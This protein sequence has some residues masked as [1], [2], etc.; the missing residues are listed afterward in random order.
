MHIELIVVS[1]VDIAP[2][3]CRFYAVPSSVEERNFYRTIG[4]TGESISIDLNASSVK[5]R[6]VDA[7]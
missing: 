7:C 5:S 4:S 1:S 2:E 6:Y 3:C